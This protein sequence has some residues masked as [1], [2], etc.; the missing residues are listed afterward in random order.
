MKKMYKDTFIVGFA[1]FAMFFGAGN[2][3]FPPYLGLVSSNK[4]LLAFAAFII[5]DLG[6]ALVALAAAARKNGDIISVFSRS[7]KKVAIVIASLIMLCLGPLLAIPRTGATTFEMGVAPLLPGA[8]TALFAVVFF[9]L[10][11]LLTIRPSKVVDIIGQYLTPALLV[12][13]IAMIAKGVLDPIGPIEQPEFIESVVAE[14]IAQG[15]QTMDALGAISLSAVIMVS[16]GQ[17][18]YTSVNSKVKMALKAGVVATVA[19][20][21]VYGGLAY[22]GAS[23]VNNYVAALGGVDPS[24]INNTQLIVSLT[25]DLL[26]QTGKIM[27]AVIVSLACLTTSVGL[28]SACGTFFSKITNNKLTYEA[29]VIAIC[30]FAGIASTLGVSNIIAIAAP[31]LSIVYP[32]T[33][34]LVFLSFADKLIKNDNVF[35]Y[36]TYATILFSTLEVIGSFNIID[37][38]FLQI[39]PLSSIGFGFVLPAIFGGVI[40]Y[41]S[42]NGNNSG[43]KQKKAEET[44]QEN[45]A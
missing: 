34:V 29:I 14:G 6:L 13:L 27:L 40:G 31:I 45:N 8:S 5:S 36:A 32:A 3:I 43:R 21:I 7:G 26:G 22:L 39:M 30:I 16:L 35:K 38:S 28:T 17:R 25:E 23:Y 12:A 9:G 19:L 37:V 24:N 1:L 11:L 10:T 18:G 4:W 15:Y 44:L 2:L 20:L 42:F 33:I 41:F